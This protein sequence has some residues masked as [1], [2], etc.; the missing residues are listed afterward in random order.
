M[1]KRL[2]Y[3]VISDIDNSNPPTISRG[4]RYLVRDE[5]CGDDNKLPLEDASNL[6]PTGNRSE[7][8]G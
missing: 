6:Q 7:I 5:E 3:F 4:W 1:R 8:Q 2:E